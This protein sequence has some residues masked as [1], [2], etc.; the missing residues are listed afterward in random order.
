VYS[1]DGQPHNHVTV[2]N[3][4]DWHVP[5]DRSGNNTA[6]VS[7][8]FVYVQG[9]DAAGYGGCA[10]NQGRFATEAYVFGYT[11]DEP[12][13]NPCANT[14]PVYSQN[15]RGQ[16]IMVD[17]TSMRDGTPLDPPQPNPLLWWQTAAVGGLNV[18][19]VPDTGMDLCVF[20]TYKHDYNLSATD[21]LNFWTALTTTPIG[22]TLEELTNQVNY[23]RMWIGMTV[24]GMPAVCCQCRVGD[25]NGQGEYPD[26]ITLG[27]IM[28]LVDVKF[29]SGDCT[30]LTCLTEADVN[31]DGGANPTCEEHV[32]LGD[33]M[34][35]VDFLFITGP[36]NATL[37]ACL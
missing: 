34:M 32:T 4:T 37:P 2:G 9:T 31:Q 35:L 12:N 15:I 23:A 28:L 22:G 14:I 5:S 6:G 18:D 10:S 11:S 1:A 3:V 29:I 16:S 21:T 13:Y 17:T 7:G 26:E 27:D 36:E 25:A 30:K 19:P 20:T 24:I 33:I 8:R